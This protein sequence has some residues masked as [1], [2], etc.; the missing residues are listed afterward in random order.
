[1]NIYSLQNIQNTQN[2][3]IPMTNNPKQTVGESQQ[4]FANNLK[5]AISNINKAQKE[6]E[7]RSPS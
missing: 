5:E 2:N 3:S 1:M 4:A 6:S 7:D